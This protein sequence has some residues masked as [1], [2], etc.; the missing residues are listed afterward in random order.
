M[1]DHG[2]YMF[3]PRDL[4]KWILGLLRYNQD[5]GEDQ[6][7]LLEAWT[8]EA[9]QLFRIKM[10]GDTDRQKWDAIMTEILSSHFGARDLF[11]KARG[12]LPT[13]QLV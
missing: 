12:M 1:D 7:S 10:A 4:T 13:F 5:D 9:I 2:H 3:T 11:P 8:Y 6:M